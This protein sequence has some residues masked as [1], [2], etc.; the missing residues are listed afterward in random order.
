MKNKAVNVVMHGKKYADG[1]TVGLDIIVRNI[2]VHL[3]KQKL[4]RRH[5]CRH[6][7][8]MPRID[9]VASTPTAAVGISVAADR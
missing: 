9:D 7:C 4:C 6:R 8:G 5:C 3:K 1:I 2:A